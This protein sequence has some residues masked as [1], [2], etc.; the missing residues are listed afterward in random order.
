MTP[1]RGR[2]V[3]LGVVLVLALLAAAAT[4]AVVAQRSSDPMALDEAS[5]LALAS[6]DESP[7]KREEIASG[8]T[9]FI[10]E[11]RS[12]L[13]VARNGVCSASPSLCR[14]LHSGC[15]VYFCAWLRHGLAH[16]LAHAHIV[17]L[18]S[19]MCSVHAVHAVTAVLCAC[20]AKCG[21][22]RESGGLRPSCEHDWCPAHA[23]APVH[24]A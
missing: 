17:F 3:K 16:P 5:A 14:P 12:S 24:S 11:L 23:H 10:A 6:G 1:E 15:A 20:T 9:R 2:G 4:L 22:E 7:A 13:D 8:G 18:Q 21:R 19:R